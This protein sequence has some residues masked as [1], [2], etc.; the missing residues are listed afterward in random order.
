MGKRY[1]KNQIYL[2]LT[3]VDELK[4]DTIVLNIL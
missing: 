1:L 2:P 3:D 4:K